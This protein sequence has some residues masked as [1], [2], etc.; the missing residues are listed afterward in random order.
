MGEA[1]M[2]LL[3]VFFYSRHA[4]VRLFFYFIGMTLLTISI[5]IGLEP[6]IQ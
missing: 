2:F 5:A 6:F 1:G 4:H 3:M